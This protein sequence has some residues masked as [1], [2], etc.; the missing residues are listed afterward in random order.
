[1][2]RPPLRLLLASALL[3]CPALAS[4]PS[5]VVAQQAAHNVVGPR[6][7]E[8]QSV[9]AGPEDDTEIQTRATF[10]IAALKRTYRKPGVLMRC[11][12]DCLQLGQCFLHARV[13]IVAQRLERLEEPLRESQ[14]NRHGASGVCP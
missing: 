6:Q 7:H 8:F 10:E 9:I 4:V 2:P 3:V 13:V 12:P 11:A 5:V 1:M 14:L